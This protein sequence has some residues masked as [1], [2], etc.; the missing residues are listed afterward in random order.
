M[1]DGVDEAVSVKLCLSVKQVTSKT[2]FTNTYL[3]LTDCL[4]NDKDLWINDRRQ[5][6][7]KAKNALLWNGDD[8]NNYE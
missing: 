6:Y 5:V 2:G 7:N 4:Q 3:M 1:E 8:C